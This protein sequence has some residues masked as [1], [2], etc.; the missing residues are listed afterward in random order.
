[1][2]IVRQ[3]YGSLRWGG[4]VGVLI[5]AVRSRGQGVCLILCGMP[6]VLSSV[7]VRTSLSWLIGGSRYRRCRIQLV[8][9]PVGG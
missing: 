8:L 2:L 5:S 6:F 1:V 7:V 3:F 9:V 4:S